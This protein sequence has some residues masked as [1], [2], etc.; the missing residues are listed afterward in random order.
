MDLYGKYLRDFLLSFYMAAGTNTQDM[1]LAQH[2][3]YIVEMPNVQPVKYFKI[4]DLQPKLQRYRA[5]AEN[6]SV[7]CY[8]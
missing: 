7:F 1:Y 8:R 6:S 5:I 4:Q 2:L 3:P